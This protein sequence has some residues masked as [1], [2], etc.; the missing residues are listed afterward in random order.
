V[1]QVYKWRDE[2][3]IWQLSDG[4]N[5][6]GGAALIEIIN[7]INLMPVLDSTGHEAAQSTGLTVP[8]VRAPDVTMGPGY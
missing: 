2:R 3:G 6:A 8:D 7:Q 1:T 4:P 5:V